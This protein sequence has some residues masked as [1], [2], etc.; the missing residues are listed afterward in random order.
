MADEQTSSQLAIREQEY[1]QLQT[2]LEVAET[3]IQILVQENRQLQM[4][5]SQFLERERAL[6]SSAGSIPRQTA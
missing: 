1:E 6:A 5:R 3:E 4:E 2:A